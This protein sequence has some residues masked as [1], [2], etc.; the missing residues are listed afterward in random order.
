[1]ADRLVNAMAN[2]KFGGGAGGSLSLH[3]LVLTDS[4]VYVVD[5]TDLFD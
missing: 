4:F 2:H 5:A 3:T 1:M